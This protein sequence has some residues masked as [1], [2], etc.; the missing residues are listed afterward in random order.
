MKYYIIQSSSKEIDR[1]IQTKFA[2]DSLM[3]TQSFESWK[4]LVAGL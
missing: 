2:I 1:H 4:F 3:I